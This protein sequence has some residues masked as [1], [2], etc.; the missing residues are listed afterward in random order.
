MAVALL[1]M[2]A[3]GGPTSPSG[4]G[5][6]GG[7]GGGPVG[8]VRVGNTYFRSS[9]NGS[10]NAAVDTISAG[11]SVTWTWDGGSHSIQSTGLSP[12]IFRN[13]V[14]QAGANQ[15]YSVTF[16]SPGTYAYDCAVHGTA[17]TGV[18]VVQ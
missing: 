7:G 6:G 14:V 9:H 3:C 13:S 15:T 4:T 18:V 1:T 8:H 5:G 17:M 2:A 10:Q 12:E 11:S 16:N